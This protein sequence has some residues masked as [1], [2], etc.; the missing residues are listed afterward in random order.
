MQEKT[1]DTQTPQINSHGTQITLPNDIRIEILREGNRFLG[2]GSI[3]AGD[4]A[5]RSNRLGILPYIETPD[6]HMASSYIINSIENSDSAAVI[7]L[8]PKWTSLGFMRWMQH[9]YHFRPNTADWCET[10]VENPDTSLQIVL[11]AEAEQIGGIAFSGF[12][13]KFSYACIIRK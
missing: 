8:T 2:L 6:G 1:K 12:S 7:N 13:Y 11:K 9:A 10:E 3:H 5:L 4:I